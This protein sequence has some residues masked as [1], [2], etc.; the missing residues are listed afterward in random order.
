VRL[1]LCICVVN[2]YNFG[3]SV[4]IKKDIMAQPLLTGKTLL[5]NLNV[6]QNY[7]GEIL[8]EFRL[9]DWSYNDFAKT[10]P[11]RSTLVDIKRLL[12][13]RHGRLQKLSLYK[14]SPEPENEIPSDAVSEGQTLESLGFAGK[15][16]MVLFYSFVPHNPTE[17][18]LLANYIRG[19]LGT[20]AGAL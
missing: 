10:F 15:K 6:A 19:T 17:P 3:S 7:S 9:I 8:I 13:E 18:T 1:Y 2:E 14:N 11:L 4:G 16:S 5:E 12:V 20:N